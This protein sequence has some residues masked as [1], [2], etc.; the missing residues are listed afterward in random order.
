MDKES[1]K[2]ASFY[3]SLDEIINY[4]KNAE[5]NEEKV[6]IDFGSEN[7]VIRL[8]SSDIDENNIYLRIYGLTKEQKN[9]YDNEISVVQN[10]NDDIITQNIKDKYETIKDEYFSNLKMNAKK[11]EF[12][13]NSLF[14]IINAL[15]EY[16]KVG[17]NVYIEYQSTSDDDIIKLYSIDFN[18]DKTFMSIM[19]ITKSQYDENKDRF[20]MAESD[21]EL[22]MVIT[23][24]YQ[25]MEQNKKR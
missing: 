6:Y 1:Y 14:D 11:V 5:N 15:N 19:G 20:K 8:Y 21:D 3:G 7:G 23:D 9:N 4:L 17:D 2:E 13:N 18:I 22:Q 12:N 24:L 10:L 16:K 25:I